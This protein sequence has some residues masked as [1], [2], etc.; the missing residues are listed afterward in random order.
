MREL[1]KGGVNFLQL[2]RARVCGTNSR[3][4]RNQGIRYVRTELD[5]NVKMAWYI[6]RSMKNAM[7]RFMC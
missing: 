5:K 4:A 1:F 2:K 7:Y 3:V 6:Y